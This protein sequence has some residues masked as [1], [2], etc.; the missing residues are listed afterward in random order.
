MATTTTW[1]PYP[2]HGKLS[3]KAL[4]ALPD[5]AFAFPT[6]RVAPLTDGPSKKGYNM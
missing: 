2:T 3:A 6:N 4:A 1:R 5:S